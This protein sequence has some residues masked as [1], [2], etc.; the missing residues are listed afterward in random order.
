MKITLLKDKKKTLSNNNTIRWFLRFAKVA[1]R[2][3][4]GKWSRAVCT[5]CK[6][7]KKNRIL[8]RYNRALR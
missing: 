1:A 5:A 7:F 2:S 6:E 4:H 8:M 3:V